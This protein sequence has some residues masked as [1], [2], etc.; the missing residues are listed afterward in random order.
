MADVWED[1]D[2]EFEERPVAREIISLV[3]KYV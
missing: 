1:S 3:K 2:A